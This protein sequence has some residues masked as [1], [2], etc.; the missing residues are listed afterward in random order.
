MKKGLKVLFMLVFIF[1]IKGIVIASNMASHQVTI[2]IVAVDELIISGGNVTLAVDSSIEENPLKDVSDNACA[3][4]WM[5]NSATNK[6]ITGQLDSDYSCG[7]S[8]AVNVGV[9]GGN[10]VS[11][12]E[13]TLISGNAVDI[14]TGMHSE[15][16]GGSII[17]Y[18]MS[19]LADFPGSETRAVIYT[20][21]DY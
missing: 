7:I 21:T 1:T 5:T 16:V 18:T 8:L 9:A 15:N 2:N 13:Q 6:K 17:G 10:S 4:D 20:I 14:V 19:A 12:G 3:L 11:T